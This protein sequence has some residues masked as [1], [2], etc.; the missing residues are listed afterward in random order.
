MKLKIKRTVM[1]GTAFMTIMMLWQVYNFTVPLFLDDMLSSLLQTGN[2]IIIGMIMAL[3][4]LFALFMIPVISHF[5]DRSKSRLGKRTPFII[6]GILLSAAAF[7]SVPFVYSAVVGKGGWKTMYLVLTLL[8]V[9]V[10]MNIYRSPAVAL[11][12]DITPKQMRSRANSIINIMGGV[13]AALG[14]IALFTTFNFTPSEAKPVVDIHTVF[15]VVAVLMVAALAVFLLTV[16]E[17]KFVAEYRAELEQYNRRLAAGE[18]SPSEIMEDED[19]D[20]DA[21]DEPIKV[22]AEQKKVKLS[23]QLMFIL[24]AVFFTYMSINAVET[25]MSLYS[26][27]L[28]GNEDYAMFFI[29]AFAATGF[30]F[31]VP[32]AKL[33]AKLG[34]RKLVILGAANM[35]V[36]Y[37]LCFLLTLAVTA[38]NITP[39]L[40]II[41]FFF[42]GVGFALVVINIYPMAVQYC[43]EKS[44]GKFTGMYYTASMLAQSIT[45]ALAGLCMLGSMLTLMPYAAAF[46]AVA[47]VCM[48][49]ASPKDK[50]GK[51]GTN[52]AAA[53]QQ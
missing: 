17:K 42:A 28:F 19:K 38:W 11:M 52:A 53:Q 35:G 32:A 27:E 47:F 2:K 46:M 30:A 26:A 6:V 15:I 7:A 10:A 3:D 41:P 37:V 18:L 8:A 45:P 50:K 23:R 34:R 24:A 25:F 21:P 51:G 1:V 14:F 29:V 48:L 43:D 12:P 13:G 33:A 9:L 49:L 22:S 39:Y 16:R 5:S 31:A 20:D 44:L 4:N 36:C 40:L